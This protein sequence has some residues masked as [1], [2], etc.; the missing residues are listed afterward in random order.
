VSDPLRSLEDYELFIYS[1]IEHFPSILR[2]TVV[3][4]RK[5]STLARVEG[6]IFFQQELRLVVRER[7]LFDRLPGLIDWYGYE[8]W[9]GQ[10]KLFW[11]DSQPHPNEVSL[12]PNHP[13]HKHIQPE[14]KH[15]RVPALEMSFLQ[16]NL[17]VII[18]EIEDLLTT[19]V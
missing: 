9:K 4:V 13:H 11:Y 8:A 19:L 10:E 16:P 2:S 6:E 12:Q 5:G 15:H 3:F 18:R 14:I 17:P 1:L 7:L